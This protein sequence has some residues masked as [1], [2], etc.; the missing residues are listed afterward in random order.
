MKQ[1]AK[2]TEHM[3]IL[4][5][6]VLSK[7]G[8]HLTSINSSLISSTWMELIKDGKVVPLPPQPKKAKKRSRK[9]GSLS[10]SETGEL[11][12]VKVI[13]TK[14]PNLSNDENKLAYNLLEYNEKQIN[15][16]IKT[17]NIG[18]RASNYKISSDMNTN[19]YGMNHDYYGDRDRDMNPHYGPPSSDYGRS[20]NMRSPLDYNGMPPRNS[21]HL[22]SNNSNN[23]NNGNYSNFDLNSQEPYSKNRNDI[24]MS[25]NKSQFYPIDTTK[26][27]NVK[28]LNRLVIIIYSSSILII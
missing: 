8:D 13:K 27:N 3:K 17:N 12:S 2:C 28:Y 9:S 4:W 14:H 25:N 19:E 24:P 6:S 22:F 7:V 20:P 11:S 21:M 23:Y 16:N 5:E 26:N 18:K 1:H 15:S 10:E